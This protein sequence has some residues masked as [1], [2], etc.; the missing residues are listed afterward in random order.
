MQLECNYVIKSVVQIIKLIKE[1]LL[2]IVLLE[3]NFN[4]QNKIN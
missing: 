1:H 4:N 2:Y 3:E